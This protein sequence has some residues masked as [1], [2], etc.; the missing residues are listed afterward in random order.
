M[1]MAVATAR[2]RW[3]G[4]SNGDG[5][6]DHVERS[7]KKMHGE[8]SMAL[9]WQW[10]GEQASTGNGKQSDWSQYEQKLKY[11]GHT[12]GVCHTNRKYSRQF[13]SRQSQCEH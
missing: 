12:V 11:L 7:A 9:S 3:P 13:N 1:A 5:E 8:Q 10:Q 2:A 4:N 6:A